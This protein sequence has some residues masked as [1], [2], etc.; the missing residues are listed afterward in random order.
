MFNETIVGN[1]C[2]TSST[3]FYYINI[4]FFL[5][6]TIIKVEKVNLYIYIYNL[7][8]MIIFTITAYLS[9]S[10]FCEEPF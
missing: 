6:N 4:D 3:N 1:K 9:V 7:H 10:Y 2:L 5:L 8:L